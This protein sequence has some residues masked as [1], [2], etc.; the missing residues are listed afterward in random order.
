M[1]GINL[2]ATNPKLELF[3]TVLILPF[4]NIN[5]VKK[6]Q[7][8]TY[9]TFKSNFAKTYSSGNVL[10]MLSQVRLDML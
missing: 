8:L 10:V 5:K 1:I 9:V 3:N 4:N 2:L 6:T 7:S